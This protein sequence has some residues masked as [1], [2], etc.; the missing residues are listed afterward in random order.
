[1]I[2]TLCLRYEPKRYIVRIGN[3][4]V[5]VTYDLKTAQTIENDIVK[6]N[7]TDESLEVKIGVKR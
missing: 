4:I 2:E 6:R 1:M 5:L 7:L 3:K